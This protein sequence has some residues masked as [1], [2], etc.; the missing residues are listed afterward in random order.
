MPP[1]MEKV[2]TILPYPIKH[3]NQATSIRLAG[4]WSEM[5]DI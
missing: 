2:F 1:F 4:C 5:I 3:I